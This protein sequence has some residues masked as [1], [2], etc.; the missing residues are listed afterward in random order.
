MLCRACHARL[1]V[2]QQLDL[3]ELLW[4]WCGNARGAGFTNFSARRYQSSSADWW[5]ECFGG[6]LQ[7]IDDMNHMW[8][9]FGHQMINFGHP[10]L[11]WQHAPGPWLLSESMWKTR[12]KN[13]GSLGRVAAQMLITGHTVVV[14]YEVFVSWF[15]FQHARV[16]VKVLNCKIRDPSVHHCL[17]WKSVIPYFWRNISVH[18]PKL[19]HQRC[20]AFDKRLCPLY[21]GVVEVQRCPVFV[22]TLHTDCTIVWCMCVRETWIY[23]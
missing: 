22:I 21:H 19:M 2:A 16:N 9:V 6:P 15:L 5:C 3:W 11:R 7:E 17:A 4:D 12:F 23:T 13:S 14:G 18:Q 1:S 8:R 10:F 20:Q